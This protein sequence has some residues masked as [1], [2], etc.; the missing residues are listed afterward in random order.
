MAQSL[1]DFA[2]LAG[3]QQQW[4][5]AVRL[6]GAA[7]TGCADLGT[8]LPIA[9]P[10]EY[11]RTVSGARTALGQEAFAA[12]WAEGRTMSLDQAVAFAL[13]EEA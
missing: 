5:R 12:A 4:E 10:A 7:E 3:R 13:T 6:L 9:M 1:E 8:P 2:G 11:W